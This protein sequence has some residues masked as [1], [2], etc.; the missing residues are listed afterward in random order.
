MIFFQITFLWGVLGMWQKG[1][2][3]FFFTTVFAAVGMILTK[4]TY[5]LHLGCFLLAA[6]V[7]W[8]WQKVLPSRP[9]LPVAKRLWTGRDAAKAAG[10]GLL[11]VVFFYSGNFLDFSILH[12]LYQ[13][14]GAWFQTGFKVTG[15]EKT[16]CDLWG[17]KQLNYYWVMLLARYE[18]PALLG[19]AA[20]FRYVT[21]SDA[22][23]RYAAIYAGGVLLAYSL[24]P[25]KTPW[26]ILS[27]LWPFFLLFGA[28]VEEAFQRFGAM[29]K[30]LRAA[31]T[32]GA[33]I[34]VLVSFG[35]SVRLNFFH[36]DDPKERY[37]YVQTFR[38]IRTLTDPVLGMAKRDPRFYHVRGLLLLDSSY[39]LPWI[40]GDF[41]QLGYLDPKKQPAGPI[42][43]DFVVME[44]KDVAKF[45]GALQGRYFKRYF[46]LRDG[47]GACVVYFREERFG[48]L[49]RLQTAEIENVAKLK[50][51]AANP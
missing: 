4:E 37:V 50:P 3:R 16:S 5:V 46:R 15:H 21:P 8:A 28:V 11:A 33:A 34:P 14:F 32:A 35:V 20:F 48:E 40:F 31:L 19:L 6:A 36:F 29:R 10:I 18:W 42:T 1:E 9:A 43:H 51:E 2:R 22:K 45:E 23:L 26:C 41:T 38:E 24:I 47:Q 7:L 44:K 25:Y 39:P 30:S 12:G 27:I 17:I 13:T 49:F